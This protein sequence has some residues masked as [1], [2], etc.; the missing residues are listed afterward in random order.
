MASS[1]ASR[2]RR[3]GR[4]RPELNVR[5]LTTA[6]PRGCAWRIGLLEHDPEKWMPIFGKDHAP[7]TSW[8]NF[9]N[10]WIAVLRTECD[11][12]KTGNAR[13][14]PRIPLFASTLIESFEHTE[15]DLWVF[16]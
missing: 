1:S 14:E 8:S 6:W 3:R 9:R 13:P 2:Q 7:T 16:A 11:Q 4:P 12:N 15:G 10:N 5:S